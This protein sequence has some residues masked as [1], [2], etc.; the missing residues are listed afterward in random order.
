MKI[1]VG[2]GIGGL[3]AALAFH[4]NGF[5]DV[6]VL[7]QSPEFG[8]IG[9]GVQISSNASR[10][11]LHY[12][13][14]DDLERHACRSEG[15]FYHDIL[16]GEALYQ[17]TAG[18]WGEE[19][20][21]A[22]H[23]HVHRADLHAI[24]RRHIPSSWIRTG[25]R[26]TAVRGTGDR[27]ACVLADGTEL[28][29][30]L[31]IGAD[32]LRST[33]RDYVAEPTVPRFT[34]FI[35]RRGLIPAERVK[36]L[37]LG[38]ACYVWSGQG[39]I[40]VVYWVSSGRLLNLNAG[41]PAESSHAESWSATDGTVELRK[42]F[43]GAT[44]IVRKLIDA[45]EHPFVTG[46]FDRSVPERLH[47][48]VAVLLGDAAHPVVPYLANGAAQA[49]EDAYVLGRVLSRRR[50][51]STPHAALA[52][53]AARRRQ[54]VD[55]VRQISADVMKSQHVQDEA[56]Q[57]RR[58]ERLKLARSNDPHGYEMRRWI[59]G[60]DVIADTECDLATTAATESV[61]NSIWLSQQP[62]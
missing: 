19:H 27:L 28:E 6:C 16:T 3:T 62:S 24:L 18:K 22:P 52:E 41:V 46:L 36:D 15:N 32:G 38:E 37:G 5:D 4:R 7:E 34:G 51:E 26:V 12:G 50:D 13:L 61:R 45:V 8:E 25:A 42:A 48:D 1:I 23:Y 40:V 55:N 59:W 14:G 11:L 39:K 9:A 47:R 31:V 57:H 60:Y 33:V 49:I 21:G 29:G 53:Y 30:D 20:Y 58:N 44:G 17:C 35:S 2:A 56:D 10:V 43:T 54:R